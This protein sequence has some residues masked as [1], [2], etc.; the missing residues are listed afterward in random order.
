MYCGPN[1][2]GVAGLSAERG[3]QGILNFMDPAN[4]K[5]SKVPTYGASKAFCMVGILPM[6]L[7]RCLTFGC[8]DPVE[9]CLSLIPETPFTCSL[10]GYI[11]KLRGKDR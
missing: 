9:P 8:V 6:V 2:F 5:G 3:V 10:R 7:G 1:G 4:L 11:L